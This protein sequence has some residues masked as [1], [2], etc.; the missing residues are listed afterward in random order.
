MFNLVCVVPFHG[1]EKGQ[2]VTDQTKV[3]ELSKDRDHHF[4]RVA[5][6]PDPEPEPEIQAE[7]HSSQEG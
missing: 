7:D 3:A 4:V 5:R 2:M 1:Y 6:A